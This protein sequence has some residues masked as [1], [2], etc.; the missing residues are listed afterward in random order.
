MKLE[1]YKMYKSFFCLLK[2]VHCY[3]QTQ[4]TQK[5]PEKFIDHCNQLAKKDGSEC[6]K[7]FWQKVVTILAQKKLSRIDV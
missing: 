7:I 5:K 4:N 2:N 6:Q 1:W 3:F